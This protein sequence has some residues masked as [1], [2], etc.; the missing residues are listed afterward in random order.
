MGLRGRSC[1]HI[2]RFKTDM[3][4]TAIPDHSLIQTKDKV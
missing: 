3:I 4:Q 1:A 2:Q